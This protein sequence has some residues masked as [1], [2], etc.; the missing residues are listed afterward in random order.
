MRSFAIDSRKSLHVDDL[1]RLF[2]GLRPNLRHRLLAALEIFALPAEDKTRFLAVVRSRLA[3]LPK[4]FAAAFTPFNS[5]CN[6]A[7]CFSSFRSSRFIAAKVSMNSPQSIKTLATLKAQ[8]FWLPVTNFSDGIKRQGTAVLTDERGLVRAATEANV[9]LSLTKECSS[10][11]L[12]DHP[13]FMRHTRNCGNKPSPL[14]PERH[15]PH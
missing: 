9:T 14:L 10:T 2:L 1:F 8:R 3:E 6:L 15:Y 5:C 4:V 12:G 7:N 11:E 13:H